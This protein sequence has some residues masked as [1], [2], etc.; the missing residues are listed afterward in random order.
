[1]KMRLFQFPIAATPASQEG[2]MTLTSDLPKDLSVMRTE[3]NESHL[4]EPSPTGGAGLSIG[5]DVAEEVV[6][7]P[8]SGSYF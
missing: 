1:M 6:I 2:D 5:Q 3:N 8:L 4:K 7:R